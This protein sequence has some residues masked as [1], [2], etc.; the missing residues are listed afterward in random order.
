M[1]LV[2]DGNGIFKYKNGAFTHLT[3][4]NGLTDNKTADILEDKQGNIWIGTF[5]GGVSKYD[6]RIYTN[7]TKEGIIKGDETYNF[8]EDKQ[9]NIWFSAEGYGV[10]PL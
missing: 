10:L 8:C 1:W 4:K 7:F 3:T 6:G 5:T 9:G 2:T